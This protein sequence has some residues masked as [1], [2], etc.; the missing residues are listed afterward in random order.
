MLSRCV[1]SC[2]VAILIALAAC[3][4]KSRPFADGF[5]RGDDTT[6]TVNS[7]NDTSDPTR[8]PP[9]SGE[10]GEETSGVVLPEAAVGG[11]QPVDAM[12]GETRASCGEDAGSCESID[13]IGS[14]P[15][16]VPTDRDCTSELDNDCDG[17]PDDA[18][19]DVCVC[20]PGSVEPCD[21]HPGQDGRGQ[22]RGGLRTCIA[23]DGNRTSS[24]GPCEGSVGP[25]AQDS[26][27][28]VGDDADCDG[29]VN[30]GCPCINGETRACGPNTGDGICQRGTQTCLN[31]TFGPCVGAVFP[32]QRDCRSTQDGDC[33][34]R[35]D[36]TV[37][38]VCNCTIGSTQV[39]GAHPGQDGFGQ[40]RAGQR[41][42]EPG[43]NNTSSNWGACTGSVGPAQSDSCTTLGDDA[44]CNGE[45]NDDCECIAG[46][47]NG[48]CSATPDTARCSAQGQCVPCQTNADCS[49]IS[50]GRNSCQGGRCTLPLPGPGAP[51]G[52]GGACA[53]KLTCAPNG[54]CCQ[55]ACDGV[56]EA[57]AAG[58]GVCQELESSTR[59]PALTCTGTSPRCSNFPPNLGTGLCAS[60]DACVSVPDYCE[61]RPLP[62]GSACLSSGGNPGKCQGINDCDESEVQCSR[63]AS[64]AFECDIEDTCCFGLNGPLC[65]AG[66]SCPSSPFGFTEI[67]VLCDERSDCGVNE[68][69]CMDNLSDAAPAIAC[70]P[71]EQCTSP[72]APLCGSPVESSACPPSQPRCLAI[73][74]SVPNWSRCSQ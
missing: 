56:C 51:C 44:N 65:N 6:D 5:P 4:G 63:G 17:R 43:P 61:P 2:K 31:G 49:L 7:E 45:E 62:V 59:C 35:P 70:R 16:C 66:T 72:R 52:T 33:D 67:R 71:V 37:D 10:F 42:C 39:C 12:S 21:E 30:G 32:L 13:D 25:E 22:C 24:W 58:S 40:C 19:D 15:A 46:Q 54:I 8:P 60:R 1:G 48:P 29:T 26:C 69:C 11:L 28:A 38:N 64:P 9:G 47:G 3:S 27:A 14:A 68:V 74:S 20:A 73:A 55:S 34:G 18:V 53:A 50:G 41:R 57:C 23:G 36:N